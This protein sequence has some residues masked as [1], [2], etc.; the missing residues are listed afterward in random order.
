MQEADQQLLEFLT[1]NASKPLDNLSDSHE[2]FLVAARERICRQPEIKQ[3]EP[4]V[5]YV[6]K[7]FHKI[8]LIYIQVV[9]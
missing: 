6:I 7:Q 2:E 1:T 4:S 5:N 8:L 9:L 3:S